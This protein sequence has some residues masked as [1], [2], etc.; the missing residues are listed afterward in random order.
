MKKPLA[1]AL[2]LILSISAC[3]NLST[4]EQRMLSGG[5]IG[6]AGG[7]TLGALTGGS[8]L[9]GALIGG[10]VGTGAGYLYHEDHN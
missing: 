2:P 7:A 6:A 10:A 3:S 4:K 8:A 5:A 1:L 9:G